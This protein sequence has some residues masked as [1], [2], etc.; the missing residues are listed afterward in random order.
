MGTP[1]RRAGPSS[2]PKTAASIPDELMTQQWSVYVDV[3]G[4]NGYLANPTRPVPP[5]GQSRVDNVH[6]TH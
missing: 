4:G 3:S 5:V 2:D 6:Y 1:Y